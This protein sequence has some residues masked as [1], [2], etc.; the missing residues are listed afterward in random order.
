MKFGLTTT[1]A[2]QV[3]LLFLLVICFLQVVWWMVIAVRR[4]LAPLF[5]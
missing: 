4:W 3:G 2:L 5:N 1:R